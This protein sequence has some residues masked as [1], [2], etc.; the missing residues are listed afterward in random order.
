MSDFLKYI[1]GKIYHNG[2]NKYLEGIISIIT[3][4]LT[5]IKKLNGNKIIE[6]LIYMKYK[7]INIKALKISFF[8]QIFK[9]TYK[10]FIF[11]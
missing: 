3:L 5:S 11:P 6:I 2:Q 10:T 7:I 8:K 4:I 9:N 1:I